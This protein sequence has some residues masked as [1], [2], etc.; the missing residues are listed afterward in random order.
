MAFSYF[1]ARSHGYL[2]HTLNR[3]TQ[4][5]GVNSWLIQ[6]GMRQGSKPRSH[7]SREAADIAN[8]VE[9]RAESAY[10]DQSRDRF[11]S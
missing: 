10:Y 5:M 6:V 9:P 8:T 7:A 11:C 4:K 3:T 2:L 1:R